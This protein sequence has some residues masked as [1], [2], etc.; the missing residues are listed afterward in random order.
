MPYRLR[1]E[2][3]DDPPCAVNH[4]TLDAAMDAAEAWFREGYDDTRPQDVPESLDEDCR[5]LRAA[6]AD[7]R[8]YY[9]GRFYERVTVEPVDGPA[10]KTAYGEHQRVVRENVIYDDGALGTRIVR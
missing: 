8:E 7:G 9:C 2:S 5:E 1:T 6:L 10:I 4:F 3:L